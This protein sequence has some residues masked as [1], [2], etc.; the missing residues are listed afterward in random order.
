MKHQYL[1]E[2]QAVCHNIPGNIRRF[3]VRSIALEEPGV[4][5][6]CCILDLCFVFFKDFNRLQYLPEA[7]LQ[8]CQLDSAQPVGIFL[9]NAV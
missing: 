9:Q 8:E 4:P 1:A 2:R 5:Q 3:V 6:H 7:F